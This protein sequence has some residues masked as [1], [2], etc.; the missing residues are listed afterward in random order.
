[1]AKIAY[2]YTS[3]NRLDTY[4]D[5]IRWHTLLKGCLQYMFT[6][7]VDI[8]ISESFDFSI[9]K[10]KFS[11]ASI[12]EFIEHAFGTEISA[13][14]IFVSAWNKELNLEP[15]LCFWARNNPEEKTLNIE[16]TSENKQYIAAAQEYLLLAEQGNAPVHISPSPCEIEKPQTGTYHDTIDCAKQD[17]IKVKITDTLHSKMFWQIAIPLFVTIVG[18]IVILFLTKYIS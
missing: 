12:E 15:L 13:E 17:T 11:C 1:M 8:N 2:T 16:I 3:P 4:N 18:G 5:V 14:T 9:S 7:N 6:N 10:T